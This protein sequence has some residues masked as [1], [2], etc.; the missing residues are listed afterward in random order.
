L[1][2]PEP[3]AAVA[4]FNE[5]FDAVAKELIAWTAATI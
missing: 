3:A 4:A 2:K 5:A 1:D